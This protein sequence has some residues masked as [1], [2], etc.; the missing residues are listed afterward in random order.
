MAN[1]QLKTVNKLPRML[2]HNLGNQYRKQ[3]AIYLLAQQH[4]L[5]VA[6]LHTQAF[7][8]ISLQRM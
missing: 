5:L 1:T 3:I 2:F 7:P 6:K 4:C 8:A